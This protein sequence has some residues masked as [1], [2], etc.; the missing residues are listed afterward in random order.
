MTVPGLGG[1]L[2]P[3]RIPVCRQRS[4]ADCDSRHPRQFM[5]SSAGD[6][7]NKFSRALAPGPHGSAFPV[8][9]QSS[10]EMRERTARI[11]Q[12]ADCTA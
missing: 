11:S 10:D 9:L 6:E 4:N 1:A 2:L 7:H 3:R 5:V 8:F 12:E